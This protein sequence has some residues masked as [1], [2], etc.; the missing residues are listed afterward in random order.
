MYYYKE[1]GQRQVWKIFLKN[2]E[3]EGQG[4]GEIKR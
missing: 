3:T 1:H 2:L 4:E